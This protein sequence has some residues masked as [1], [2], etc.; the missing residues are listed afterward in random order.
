MKR[1]RNAQAAPVSTSNLEA[2]GWKERLKASDELCDSDE[3]QI[4][5]VMIIFSSSSINSRI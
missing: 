4:I 3:A 1:H 5:N 2:E